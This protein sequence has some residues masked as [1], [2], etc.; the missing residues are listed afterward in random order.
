MFT[1]ASVTRS[2]MSATES[3]PFPEAAKL[4]PAAS[5]PSPAAKPSAAI[6]RS[7]ILV[8]VD[9]SILERRFW[10]DKLRRKTCGNKTKGE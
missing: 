1:T 5:T 2:A 8:S 4:V 10:P 7:E 9:M 6:E 3:G